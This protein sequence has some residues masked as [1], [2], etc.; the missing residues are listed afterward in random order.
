MFRGTTQ[1]GRDIELR[2]LEH[3]PGCAL[4]LEKP[5]ATGPREEIR[6]AFEVARRMKEKGAVCGVG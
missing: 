1:P 4:F 2:V 3:L 6:E 5:I